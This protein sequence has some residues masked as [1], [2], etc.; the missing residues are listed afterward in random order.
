[1]S[2]ASQAS[3][4]PPRQFDFHAKH[5]LLTYAQCNRD[6]EE[7]LQFLITSTGAEYVVVGHELHEDGG[8]HL[9]AFVTFKR[10]FRTRDPRRFDFSGFHP[11]IVP[12]RDQG[13]IDYAKKDGDWVEFGTPPFTN[14]TGSVSRDAK[15]KGILD[16]AQSTNS[17]LQLVRERAPYEYVTQYAKL[18]DFANHHY[19]APSEYQSE[20]TDF[21]IRPEIQAWVDSEFEKEVNYPHPSG[22]TL[23]PSHDKANLYSAECVALTLTV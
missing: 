21:T 18:R 10:K 16:D 23:C 17:F 5:A 6:K 4:D 12:G 15:W 22:Q 20:F 11:N 3:V 1:M 13:G 2:Q 7:L 14:K 8:D 9:H 19:N